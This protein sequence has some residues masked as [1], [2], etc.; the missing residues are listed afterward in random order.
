MISYAAF[1]ETLKRSSES[2][3]T[4]I[5]DYHISSS[6]IDKLRKNKPL[7]TTTINDLC[8]ILQCRVQDIMEY[9]PSDDDQ[10]L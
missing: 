1:W 8:R 7:N 10:V 2:T 5:K 4:L 6:T 3:Y 9:M